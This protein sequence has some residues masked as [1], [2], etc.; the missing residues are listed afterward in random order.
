MCEFCES[1]PVILR[2]KHISAGIY[3][4]AT[5]QMFIRNTGHNTHSIRIL[6]KNKEALP[7]IVMDMQIFYCPMCGESFRREYDYEATENED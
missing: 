5:L 4:S 2:E 1:N 3:G 6:S 7:E